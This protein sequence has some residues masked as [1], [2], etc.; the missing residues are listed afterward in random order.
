MSKRRSCISQSHLRKAIERERAILGEI[1]E[2]FQEMDGRYF[3]FFRFWMETQKRISHHLLF[4][5]KNFRGYHIMKD[6]MA[7]ESSSAPQ[8]VPSFEY[9]PRDYSL[10][11]ELDRPLDELE[12]QLLS[13]FAGRTC[14]LPEIYKEHCV[15]KR[16]IET[17]YRQALK[18]LE[19]KSVIEVHSPKPRRKGTFAPHVRIK[20]PVR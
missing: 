9:N 13:D 1:S 8:G 10:H 12:V 20:F 17:N 5:S 11:F 4:V 2:A 6:I 3:L 16:F 7:K 19:D 14:N 18:N 15:G